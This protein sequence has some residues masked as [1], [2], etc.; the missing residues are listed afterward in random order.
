MGTAEPDKWTR[1]YV[2]VLH[3]TADTP[4]GTHPEWWET[5]GLPPPWKWEDHFP[6]STHV[7]E[8]FAGEL[9]S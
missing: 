6:Q 4:V 1:Q 3:I 9:M 8:T 2:V 7:K 5:I